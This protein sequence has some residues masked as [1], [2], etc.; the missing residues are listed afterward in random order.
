LD[1]LKQHQAYVSKNVTANL[2]ERHL[3]PL[4]VRN[5]ASRKR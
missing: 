1:A 4:F 3:K 5:G 2:Y